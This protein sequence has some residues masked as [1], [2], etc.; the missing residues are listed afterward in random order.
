[1]ASADSNKIQILDSNPTGRNMEEEAKVE[2][3]KRMMVIVEEKKGEDR[4]GGGKEIHKSVN[5]IPESWGKD[6]FLNEW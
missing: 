5:W 3:M 2:K 4:R 6:N 1:M